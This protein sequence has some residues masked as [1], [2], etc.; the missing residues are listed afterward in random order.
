MAARRCANCGAVLSRY[1][2][3]LICQPCQ[4]KLVDRRASATESHYLDVEGMRV[5]LGLESQEQVRRLA[6][7]GRLPPRVPVVRRW[8]WEEEVV[9]DWI[10]SGHETG[11]DV[12]E[13]LQALTKAHG[14]IHLDE[15]T[16]ERILG[17]RL[18]IQVH[19]Y[20]RKGKKI[21]RETRKMSTVVPRH[22]ESQGS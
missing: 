14:G 16:G 22:H 7:K 18:D 1:N 20:S 8:L 2:P 11:P 3:G 13:Q 5:I 19:V 21:V 9:R 4:E 15:T 10:R 17:D 12:A 6:R